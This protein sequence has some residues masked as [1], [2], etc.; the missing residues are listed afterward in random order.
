MKEHRL[1]PYHRKQINLLSIA[2]LSILVVACNSSKKEAKPLADQDWEVL[3]D[4][5]STDAFRGYGINEFPEGVWIVENGILMTNP[6]TANRDL[7]TKKRYK[8]FELEYEWAV[9]TAANSGVFFH[10]QENLSMEAGNGNSPNWMDNFEIQILEDTYFYDTTAIRSAGS[11][12]DL[13]SPTNKK[14]NPIGEFN[15]AVLSH[16]S[17]HVAHWLNGDKVL[18][19]T[20]GS[21]AMDSLLAVSK[22]KENP[23]FHTDKEGHLMFQHHGQKVYFR[24]I[25]VRPL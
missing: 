12:Y 5:S 9:D 2:L 14:L 24:N 23:D 8:D 16:K 6:D 4:G 1:P 18:E 20:I 25:R 21:P 13:I 11:L 19:F 22:F 3:F 17:G 10:M 7:I 15:K